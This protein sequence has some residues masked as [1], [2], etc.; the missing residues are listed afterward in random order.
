MQDAVNLTSKLLENVIEIQNSGLKTNILVSCEKLE[1]FVLQ[2]ASL[3]MKSHNGSETE[4]FMV[5]QEIGKALRKHYHL[6]LLFY[7][8]I[9]FT[10]ITQIHNY[11]I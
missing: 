5:Q 10:E 2:Y 9:L 4:L 6:A 3:H 8:K 1:K 7:S 11:S